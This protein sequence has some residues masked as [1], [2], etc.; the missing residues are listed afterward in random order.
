MPVLDVGTGVG[1]RRWAP[2]PEP[3]PTFWRLDGRGR[4][5]EDERG[6]KGGSRDGAGRLRGEPDDDDDVDDVF[7]VVSTVVEAAAGAGADDGAAAD[8]VDAV[9]ADTEAVDEV[10]ADADEADDEAERVDEAAAS[11]GAGSAGSA[12]GPR[13]ES[14]VSRVI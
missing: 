10:D 11:V 13:V 1:Y 9:D 3:V 5:G 6:S 14:M 4:P 7:V 8:A 12:A 2:V